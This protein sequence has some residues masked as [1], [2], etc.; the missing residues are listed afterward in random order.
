MCCKSVLRVRVN[1]VEVIQRGV[2]P[3]PPDTRTAVGAIGGALLGAAVA[4]PVGF[5]A[6]LL[7]GGFLGAAAETE[8][9][10]EEE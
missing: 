8:D 4:G 1:H 9:K 7:L 10:A 3:L 2:V 5:F 6:G